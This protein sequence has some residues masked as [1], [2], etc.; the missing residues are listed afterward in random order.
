MKNLSLNILAFVFAVLTPVVS[1]AQTNAEKAVFQKVVSSASRMKSMVADFKETKHLKMLSDEVVTTGKLW[2]KAPSFMRWEYDTK[3]YGVYNLKGGYMVKNGVRDGAL[4]RGFSQMGKMVT[5]LLTTLSDNPK[6]FDVSY[7]IEG[8]ELVVTAVP[9]ASRLKGT[10]GSVVMK[11]D[12][13][14]S[15]VKSFEIRTEAGYTLITFSSVKTDI[16]TDPQ[17]FN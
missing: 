16:E 3:N 11:F 12:S 4:S 14:T 5:G 1:S 15:L 9:K 8:K 17:L 6:D 13:S 2:Y 7:K 10:V